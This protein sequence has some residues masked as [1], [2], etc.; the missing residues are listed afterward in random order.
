MRP[1]AACADRPMLDPA[2]VR[3]AGSRIPR[4]LPGRGRGHRE[5]G[6]RLLREAHR[7]ACARAGVGAGLVLPRCEHSGHAMSSS[8]MEISVRL[9][10]TPDRCTLYGIIDRC[11]MSVTRHRQ[12]RRDPIV[13]GGHI[14]VL[15]TKSARA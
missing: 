1:V 8:A 12:A 10:L 2:L 15:A 6:R 9:T 3:D 4:S 7:V 5:V 11:R 13:N 14:D